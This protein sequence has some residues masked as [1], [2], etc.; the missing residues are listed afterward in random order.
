MI[1]KANDIVEACYFLTINEHRV[2]LNAISQIDTTKPLLTNDV[3][4]LR[5]VEFSKIFNVSSDC[6]YSELSKTAK[7]LFDRKLSIF[8]PKSD[9]ER[10]DIRW[11]SSVAYSRQRGEIAL[12]FS[13]EILPF[14]CEMKA[15]FTSYNLSNISRMTSIYGIRLYELLTQYRTVGKR[16]FE[17][18][19]LKEILSVGDKHADIRDFKKNVIAPAVANIDKH[20]DLEIYET[21]YLKIGRNIVSVVF[22]FKTKTTDKST[23][24]A[25]VSRKVKNDDVT[26]PVVETSIYDENVARF[27]KEVADKIAQQAN[28]ISVKDAAVVLASLKRVKV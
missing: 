26:T 27:G 10:I 22:K 25:V 24:Q 4:I 21:T 14:L 15:R 11:L 7:M 5:A 23:K 3:F 18:S 12:R 16:R 8:N 6:V 9:I 19:Q 17:I 2:L 20:S 13:Q 28:G 1:C